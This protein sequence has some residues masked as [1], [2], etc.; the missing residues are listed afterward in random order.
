MYSTVTGDRL[1][2]RVPDAAYWV[3]NLCAPVLFPAAIGR[4]FDAGHDTFLEISPHPILLSEVHAGADERGIPSTLLRS[5][6]RDEPERATMLAS[7]GALYTHGQTVA[8]EQLHSGSGRCVPAPT[9]P[10]Q[11]QRFWLDERNAAE[12]GIN[13]GRRRLSAWSPQPAARLP[14]EPASTKRCAA[15][16]GR[17]ANG[18]SSHTWALKPLANSV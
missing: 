18:C 11:R 7:L 6:C 10:W 3:E 17:S 4:L 12:V 15:L 1:V 2:D 13:D 8:W 14:R 9:Y 16:A 5:M